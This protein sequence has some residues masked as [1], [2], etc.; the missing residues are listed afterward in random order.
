MRSS[1]GSSERVSPELP[2][3][4]VGTATSAQ[5]AV[6]FWRRSLLSDSLLEKSIK[7]VFE[8]RRSPLKQIF[9]FVLPGL[10]VVLSGVLL[11][12]RMD[13]S[14][15]YWLLPIDLVVKLDIGFGVSPEEAVNISQGVMAHFDNV[16]LWGQAVSYT[17]LTLPT[18]A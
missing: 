8:N 14:L 13:L 6:F 18:K 15:W 3:E 7:D 16:C 12:C 17:H 9:A 1:Y 4:R 2:R 11:R 5:G 10:L